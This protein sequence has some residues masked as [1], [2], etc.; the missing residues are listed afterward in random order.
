M[1]GHAGPQAL[2]SV[3]PTGPHPQ[4][5]IPGRGGA[6]PHQSPSLR[7][8]ASVSLPPDP[9]LQSPT[10]CDARLPLSPPHCPP[11]PLSQQAPAA[12]AFHLFLK[13]SKLI[14][15]FWPLHQL[16][17]LLE[18]LSPSSRGW[19]SSLSG[20]NLN[21]ISSQ[22]PFRATQSKGAPYS[23]VHH[24]VNVLQP[25]VFLFVYICLSLTWFTR[26]FLI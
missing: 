12:P 5:G 4:K 26:H 18:I 6:R 24:S 14:L 20:F 13:L 1:L 25:V 9:G 3:S 10:H 8:L 11:H 2:P 15:T 7:A 22:R 19:S 23:F 17:L 21:I 16:F